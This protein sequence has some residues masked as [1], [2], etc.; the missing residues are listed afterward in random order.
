M[1]LDTLIA[2]C[3]KD[4]I[5]FIWDDNEDHGAVKIT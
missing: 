2:Q 3:E 1:E 4:L 5:T